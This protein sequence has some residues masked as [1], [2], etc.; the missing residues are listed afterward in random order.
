M[1]RGLKQGKGEKGTLR[2]TEKQIGAGI[3]WENDREK[4]EIGMF[5]ETKRRI[6]FF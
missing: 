5:G 3:S 2:E 4:G 1:T 6:G